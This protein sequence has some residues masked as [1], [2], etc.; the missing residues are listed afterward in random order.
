MKTAV[1]QC[2]V[3]CLLLLEKEAQSVVGERGL[4][5]KGTSFG[6]R[7]GKTCRALSP[8]AAASS[9]SVLFAMAAESLERSLAGMMHLVLDKH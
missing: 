6:M 5:S 4:A 9:R 8:V 2:I 3:V 1:E 7:D